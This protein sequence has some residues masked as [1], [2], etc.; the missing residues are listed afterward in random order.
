MEWLNNIESTIDFT[1]K[2]ENNTWPFLDI[3]TNEW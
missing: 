3:F 2:L 1:Y